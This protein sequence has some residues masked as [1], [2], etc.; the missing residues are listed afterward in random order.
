LTHKDTTNIPKRVPGIGG[1][2]RR[3]GLLRG[4]HLEEVDGL[5]TFALLHLSDKVNMNI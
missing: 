1:R 3:E 2:G 5:K 4:L